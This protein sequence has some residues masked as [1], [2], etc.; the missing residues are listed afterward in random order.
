MPL[1]A[2]IVGLSDSV[3]PSLVDPEEAAADILDPDH[4][5]R[6][7]PMQATWVD[8][9]ALDRRA[10][11]DPTAPDVGKPIARQTWN[12]AGYEIESG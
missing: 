6:P 11:P 8:A 2:I 7:A 10:T 12:G 4:Q 5:Y 1:L 9:S 3:D